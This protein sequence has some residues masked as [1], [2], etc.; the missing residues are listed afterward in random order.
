[1]KLFLI[2]ISLLLL[3]ACSSTKSVTR[4]H[5]LESYPPTDCIMESAKF[6]KDLSILRYS[7]SDDTSLLGR[8]D[9]HAADILHR[10]EY[11]YRGIESNFH[12]LESYT[13]KAKFRHGFECSN[14]SSSKDAIQEM[15]SFLIRLEQS[16]FEN[17]E[18]EKSKSKEFCKGIACPA[19]S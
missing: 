14:C 5:Y 8:E 17:C 10:F 16:L 2:N 11:N 19:A 7:K 3:A 18:I 1:M 12:F 6:V 4:I 9:E 13:G 15:Y